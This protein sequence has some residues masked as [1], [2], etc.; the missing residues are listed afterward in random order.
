MDTVLLIISLFVVQAVIFAVFG[1][2]LSNSIDSA[3]DELDSRL[4][5]ALKA[6]IESL[7]LGEIEPPNP[8]LQIL[9]QAVSTNMNKEPNVDLVRDVAG[10]FTSQND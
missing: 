5:L 6:T 3:I 4:A 2:F 1:W 9:A 7:P 10:K 8:L